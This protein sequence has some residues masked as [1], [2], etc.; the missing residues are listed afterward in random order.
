MNRKE[1][2]DHVLNDLRSLKGKGSFHNQYALDENIAFFEANRS[3]PSYIKW[4][5][6]RAPKLD[7]EKLILF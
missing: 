1:I 2:I 3:F 5:F 7:G 6:M 4:L